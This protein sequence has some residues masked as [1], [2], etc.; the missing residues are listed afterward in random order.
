MSLHIIEIQMF[1]FYTIYGQC[2]EN[3]ITDAHDLL[4]YF[5]ANDIQ[6]HRFFCEQSQTTEL[7]QRVLLLC[8]ESISE[9]MTSNHLELNPSKSEFRWWFTTSSIT[10]KLTTVPSLL[11]VQKFDK[12]ITSP[13]LE[14][15]LTLSIKVNLLA[16]TDHASQLV[17][18]C[19]YQSF[20]LY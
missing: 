2:G 10:I 13:T 8:I 17:R 20:A 12:L 16:L 5:Y 15:T 14:F 3:W 11:M 19:F 7:R 6:L 9:R 1:Y 4:C 18:A